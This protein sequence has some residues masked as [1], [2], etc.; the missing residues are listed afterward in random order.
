[1]ENLPTELIL[2]IMRGLPDDDFFKLVKSSKRLFDIFKKHKKYLAANRVIS[3]H[4][5]E[6]KKI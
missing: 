3:K 4:L 2:Q 6:Q 5:K 1:M